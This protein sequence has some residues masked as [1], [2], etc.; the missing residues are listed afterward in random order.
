MDVGRGACLLPARSERLVNHVCADS[1]PRTGAVSKENGKCRKPATVSAGL[2]VRGRRLGEVNTA[3]P[4]L[5][6]RDMARTSSA[7]CRCRTRLNAYILM[8]TA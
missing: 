7:S 4:K 1:K 2:Q 3:E 6:L 5:V 8:R